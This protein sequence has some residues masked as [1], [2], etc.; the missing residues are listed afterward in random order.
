MT[1]DLL[2]DKQCFVQKHCILHL[3]IIHSVKKTF[4][5]LIDIIHDEGRSWVIC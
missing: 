5:V 4:P 3:N 1:D 2:C